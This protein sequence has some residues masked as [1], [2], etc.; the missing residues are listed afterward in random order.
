MPAMEV[1]PAAS[2]AAA[3][4]S[5]VH[6]ELPGH[7]KEL[8]GASVRSG[9]P[10]ELKI[11]SGLVVLFL[12]LLF[13]IMVLWDRYGKEIGEL[14]T[15]PMG[16]TAQGQNASG[17]RSGTREKRRLICNHVQL[18][19]S[20]FVGGGAGLAGSDC[21]CAVAL[22][23]DSLARCHL[24]VLGQS[25]Q[26][27]DLDWERINVDAKAHEA[28]GSHRVQR[29]RLSEEHSAEQR[30]EHQLQ[31]TRNGL[32]DRV[33]LLEE[34]TRDHTNERH[35]E[36]HRQHVGREKHAE[37]GHGKRLLRRLAGE[38][39]SQHP[40]RADDRV[41]VHEDVLQ[42]HR[43]R[44][45][46]LEQDFI[47]H[48]R[49]GA[50]QHLHHQKSVGH[51]RRAVA[52]LGRSIRVLR[53]QR[54]DGAPDRSDPQGDPL[55]AV[56][57]LGEHHLVQDSRHHEA[58]LEQQEVSRGV[59]RAQVDVGQHVVD[60]VEPRRDE[61]EQQQVAVLTGL[62][63]HE[64]EAGAQRLRR[65]RVRCQVHVAG[66]QQLDQRLEHHGAGRV[67]AYALALGQLVQ[68]P[69]AHPEP[70]VRDEDA[71]LGL[72]LESQRRRHDRCV[73]LAGAIVGSC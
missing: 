55:V 71:A 19:L 64:A 43:D 25:R 69:V 1:T 23:F 27:R 66:Q 33:K 70:H 56:Q 26:S 48:A 8:L 34:E 73:L 53:A 21:I 50:A 39:Q 52:V 17:G 46:F 22:F 20:N 6:T 28:N 60:D 58:E 63:H 65:L 40:H 14:Y 24:G 72:G 3:A 35:D 13:L 68:Q 15:S 31:S 61:V 16:T 44:R 41:D 7:V 59:E 45:L 37:V 67:E 29:D 2:A 47:V 42:V 9:I 57:L 51:E 30:Q 36:H 5:R 32:A 49:K 4:A 11:L 10:L 62:R 18:I 12:F 38:P 54:L